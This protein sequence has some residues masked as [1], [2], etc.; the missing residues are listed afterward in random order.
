MRDG[1][2][3][4]QSRGSSVRPANA[5]VVSVLWDEEPGV[6]VAV[7]TSA[8][9]LDAQLVHDVVSLVVERESLA[10]SFATDHDVKDRLLRD[11]LLQGSIDEASVH[12]LARTLG[13][14]LERPRSV[15]LVDASDYVLDSSGGAS[16]HPASDTISARRI[17]DVIAAIALFFSLPDETICVHISGGTVG[18]LK[19]CTTPDLLEWSD[20]G[21]AGGPASWANLGA[22]KRAAT[23]LCAQMERQLHSPIDV[24]VGRYHPGLGGLHAS[25]EDCRLALQLGRAQRP[26]S[27]HSLDELGVAAL[28]AADDEGIKRSLAARLIGPLKQEAEMLPTLRA[29]FALNCSSLLTARRLCIHR[30]TL[31]YRLDKVAAL[32]G[33]DPRNF[34][35]AVQL[36][37][38]L[39]LTEN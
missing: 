2:V 29:F 35:E 25:Y 19:A 23:G 38:S 13:L 28:V 37:I 12:R 11:L 36:R 3:I 9:R 1:T 24:A 32:T 21:L 16:S 10:E 6:E 7:S 33:L 26:G 27:M 34:N 8:A 15:L 20:D 18:V 17:H 14:N 30:N 4:A 22:L 31:S 5:A 39:E